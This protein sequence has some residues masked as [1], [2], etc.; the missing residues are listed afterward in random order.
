MTGPEVLY[1]VDS[2]V[3]TIT[4]NRP[5]RLNAFDGRT[6]DALA[7]AVRAAVEDKDVRVIVMTGAGRGFCAGADLTYLRKIID[8]RD[9]KAARALID[10]GGAIVCALRGSGKPVIAA[11]NGAAAGGGAN[12]A[13]A[14][15]IRLASDRASIGQTFNRIGLQPDWGGSY[16]LPRLVGDAKALELIFTGDMIDAAEALRIGLFNRVVPHDRL[17]EETRALATKLAAKPPLALARAKQAIY[18]SA[19]ATLGAMLESELQNQL[20]LF[21]TEDAR[22]GVSAFNEKRRAVFRGV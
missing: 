9:W 8:T 21:L 15:D 20:A 7:E 12:L 5:D 17:A 3:G 22:E 1:S 18:N 11:I 13:L 10:L 2:Q 19:H 14:C 4:L 6:A 16:L